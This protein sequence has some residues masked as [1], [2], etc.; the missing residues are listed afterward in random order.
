MRQQAREIVKRKI[1]ILH[2][3]SPK[4]GSTSIQQ[5]LSQASSNGQLGSVTYPLW[6]DH[7]NQI[8]LTFLYCPHVELPRWLQQKYRTDSPRYR[9]MR[10][11]L[12]RF[13]FFKLRAEQHALLSAE[14]LFIFP[15]DHVA[16]LR[17]D[18]ESCGFT[19]FRIVLYIRE[20]ASQ[21]LSITQQLLKSPLNPR[22]QDPRT[23]KYEFLHVVNIWE[24]VFPNNLIV[25]KFPGDSGQDVTED[26]SSLLDELLG[27]KPTPLA[28]RMNTSLSAEGMHILLNYR[29]TFWANNG[30][31]LT[32]D[33]NRLVKSLIQSSN[34]VPQTRPALKHEVAAAIRANHRDDVQAILER[35]GIDLGLQ[36]QPQIIAPAC[37]ANLQ[38]NDIL[39]SINPDIVEQLLMELL[40]TEISSKVPRSRFLLRSAK[41]LYFSI[42]TKL[43]T[44]T[45]QAWLKKRFREKVRHS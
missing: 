17:R 32:A 22:I 42:P 21:Y 14:N 20:P 9:F 44:P 24:S 25:R 19:D 36:H 26:F 2:I 38:L 16:Q 3:G 34:L 10:S 35:Y 37:Q 40:K 5:M 15:H 7:I 30:G 27:V 12:R 23:F 11:R 8:W 28:Q 45:L 1:A 4:T 29:Q 39:Q 43:R 31:W 13:F 6:R 41:W 33:I 18:L